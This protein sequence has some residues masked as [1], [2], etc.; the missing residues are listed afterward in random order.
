MVSA[1]AKP[2]CRQGFGGRSYFQLIF[3][4][5]KKKLRKYGAY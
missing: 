3:Y 1:F 2:A 4:K 5:V